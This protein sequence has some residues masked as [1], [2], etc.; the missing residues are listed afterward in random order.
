M[1]FSSEVKTELAKHLGKSRHCQI[2]ELAALIAFEGRIPAA[3]SENRLLMQKYQLLLAELFHIEEIHT[4]EETRSVFSTVKMYNDVTGDPEPEDTVKGLLIQQSCCKR[5]YIRGAFLAGGS[6]SDPN[7]SYHFEIVCRSIPQA[8]QLRDVINSFDMDAKIV[9]RKKYQ[10]VYLKEGSQIVD[11]LN[12]MEAHV[13]LMNL[14]NVRILK[15]MR[16]SVNRKV[17]CETANISKT[18]NAAVKQLAD[19]EYIRET[20]GLSYLP[21]NLKEMALLR[22]EYP[23]APLAELGTYL[24]PP[25]GKS[26]VN[27]RLRRISEMADSLR[28]QTV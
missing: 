25:V 21:E 9:A 26:G 3:E 2:A 16:N 13:A 10:V 24:N 14:E 8:E 4:A 11:I 1:S 18:V 12:I 22:L 20:A 15:E 17:N 6:I 27:H 28:Q 19:I 23:D 5:A 7:K